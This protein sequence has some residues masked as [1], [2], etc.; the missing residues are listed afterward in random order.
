MKVLLVKFLQLKLL[1]LIFLAA[2]GNECLKFKKKIVKNTFA[3][4]K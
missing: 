2:A 4:R 1:Y 3:G